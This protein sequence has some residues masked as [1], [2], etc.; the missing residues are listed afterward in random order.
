MGEQGSK[1]IQKE[2][3]MKYV[4]DYMFH[5]FSEYSKLLRYKPTVPL[6]ATE[7]CS[8]SLFCSGVGVKKRF[9]LQ[10]LVESPSFTAPCNMP[11]PYDPPALRDFLRR[12]ENLTRQVG[13]WESG[14]NTGA[15]EFI[16]SM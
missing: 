16:S 1:F 12:K 4:Y 14:N 3:H 7:V 6:N 8:E 10:S 11:K 13:L 15:S 2:V 5:L 9:K